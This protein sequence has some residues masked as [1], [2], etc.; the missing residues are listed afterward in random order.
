MSSDPSEGEVEQ[1]SSDPCEGE[2]KQVNNNPLIWYLWK[3]NL[4]KNKIVCI[5]DIHYYHV[6]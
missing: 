3:L 6:L 5:I 4:F 2:V 1:V